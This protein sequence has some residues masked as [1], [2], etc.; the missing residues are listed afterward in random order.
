MTA[1]AHKLLD[2]LVED[3]KNTLV[4]KQIDKIKAE[5][6]DI[7]VKKQDNFLQD[8]VQIC[9]SIYRETIEAAGE[10]LKN[11]KQ[12]MLEVIHAMIKQEPFWGF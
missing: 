3:V 12:E 6:L 11:Q 1:A 8:M 9:D 2:Q 10:M 7:V 5:I 4:K